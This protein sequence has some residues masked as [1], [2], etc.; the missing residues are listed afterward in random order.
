M[1]LPINSSTLSIFQVI[2]AALILLIAWCA[3]VMASDDAS[4]MRYDRPAEKWVEAL[5]V[6]NGR[7][8]AMVFGG[9]AKERIQFNEDSLWT[10]TSES[11]PNGNEKVFGAYQAFGD[12]FLSLDDKQ[13]DGN[14]SGIAVPADYH[15]K[16]DLS[17]GVA[18][19]AFTAGSTP[20]L[21]E[22]F[23]SRPDEVLVTRWSSVGGGNVNGKIELKGAHGESTRIDGNT[24]IFEGSLEN[25]ERYAA[26]ARVIVRGGNVR[27]TDGVLQ[28][29]GADEVLVLTAAGTDYIF[30]TA[31]QNKSGED[32]LPKILKQLEAASSKSFENLKSSHISAHK[33]LME[34]VTLDLGKST[35]E[36]KDLPINLRKVKAVETFDPELEALLF[37][38]GRY[39]LIGSS[40]PGS[41]PANLQGLWNELNKPMWACDYHA[42]INVQ[43]NYWCAETANM[44]EA[45]RPLFDWIRSMIPVW[46]KNTAAEKEFNTASGPSRGWAVRTMLNPWGGE[47]FKWDKTANAWLCQHFWE[48]Y[49]FGGDKVFLKE[50]AYPVMKE[51]VEFWEDHLK[52]L[53]DGRLVVPHGWSPEHGPEEDGVSYNQ[54]IVW[55]LFTNY[56]EAADALGVDKDYRDK[57]AGMREKLVGP[58]I[59]KWGQLQEWMEDKSG[60]PPTKDHLDTPDDHHRHTSHLFAV[61][62]GRQISMA[63]TPEL[64]KAAKVSL[65]ARGIDAKSDVREWS[66]AWRTS[67]YARL[68]DGESSHLMLKNLFSD[69]N[70]CPN[71]FGLH[72]PLQLDGNFGI[73]AGMAEMLVQSHEGEIN[74]LPALP[75]SWREGSVSGL[76]ARGGFTIDLTWKQGRLDRAVIHSA[77]GGKCIV[78][79]G[80]KTREIPILAGGSVILNPAL[81]AISQAA[82]AST[83]SS[84]DAQTTTESTRDIIPFNREWKFQLGDSPGAEVPA[85]DDSKWG[86]FGLPHTFS[87]PYFGSSK[88]YTGYGWYRKHLEAPASWDGRK[89]FLEF[90]GA[91]RVAEVYVNGRLVGDHKGGY[92][93]FQIDITKDL[94]PGDNVIAVRVN[95]LWDPKLAPRAGEHVFSGGIYRDVRI[96]VT[97]PLHV[98]WYGTFV[99]T[100]SVSKE[101][102]TVNVKTEVANDSSGSKTATVRSEIL[103]PEGRPVTAMDS[104]LPISAGQSLTFDQTSGAIS[105]PRLWSPEHPELYSVKTTVLEGGKPVDTFV[106][107]LGFRTIKFTA[108]QGFFLNGEHRYL[109]GANVH[110]DHAG[111]G[112]AVAAGAFDRDVRMV[113]DAGFDFIR[114]SH[115]PHS[116]AF[117]EAC[118][119]N[120]VMLWSENCFWGI[121]GF[122]PDAKAAEGKS[123]YAVSAYPPDSQDWPVFDESVK[124]QL[125]EMIRIHRNHPSVVAW[126]MAN[127]AFFSE[128]SVMPRVK[129]F[130][131]EL[132]ELTHRLDPTRPAAIGGVQRPLD[133]GRIDKVGDVAGYNGDGASKPQFQN[134]GVPNIVAEYGSTT[135]VRPGKY[136]PGWGEL[137]KENGEGVF[138]WR[139]GQSI[140]CMF[141]HGSLAGANLGHMGIV[142][143]FRIPK[144]AWYWYRE[145]HRQIPPPAWPAEGI[146][147]ALRLESDTSVIE[148]ADGTRDARILVTVLDGNGLAISNSPP[149]TLSIESGP[150]EFPTGTSIAFDQKTDIPI[151]DGQ[152]AIE[153]RSCHAGTTVLR[154]TSPGLKD[155]TLTITTKGGPE[156]IPGKT[157]PVAPRPYTRFAAGAPVAITE[158]GQLNPAKASSQSPGHDSGLANDGNPSTSWQ[159]ASGDVT[160]W[161]RIDLEKTLRISEAALTLPPGVPANYSIEISEDGESGWKEIARESSGKKEGGVF[162]TPVSNA[163]PTRFLRISFPS[164]AAG[165]SEFKVLAQPSN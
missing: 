81:E 104:T 97:D 128:K 135:A 7:I 91:F 24:L 147:T 54:E 13:S 113:R 49:A 92:T 94:H 22:V 79:Y 17:T 83:P 53:P 32:P 4:V 28:I 66:F 124:E 107:P 26:A 154:A 110:Q 162:K 8:G 93:G 134:P 125:V 73:T 112:D 72:P 62:P 25:G 16:L 158:F 69:R 40:R 3:P 34:R 36:Q 159:P 87:L 86:I 130:L 76:R 111:W 5:P 21:R 41:L 15:R 77:N 98:A 103:D 123:I 75:S 136:E 114:G 145:H 143:Y 139:S 138:P 131:G 142:D 152:A 78:R 47:T 51:T 146:P 43:M 20:H 42:N 67:L 35:K 106:S 160:P 11:R 6:G 115:Y 61:H 65:D 126:S 88:F 50:E 129:A 52:A 133:E 80:E 117:S 46:R 70:T 56:I 144:R 119:K 151:R 68:H 37:Q 149:V 102:A 39:L 63:K 96:V 164:S 45:H 31:K 108:D 12:L 59:G 127:E 1:K 121:G 18:T 74:L 132:V 82:A 48:H 55:D 137:A 156:F 118:D 33:P 90:D 85:F 84:P 10:G 155:A 161:W 23:A 101:S 140:W 148:S 9:I 120:G 29:S 64:A 19:T 157:A 57:I 30:D 150:G 122:Q 105:S 58:K 27:A 153:F 141:D 165:I 38:Y 44:P 2:G 14:P 116:P 60:L 95:N 109:R 163:S 89:V 71:L 99:T 100:P